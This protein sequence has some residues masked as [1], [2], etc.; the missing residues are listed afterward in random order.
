MNT[1][2]PGWLG[3]LESNQH[4][5]SQSLLK[6]GLSTR[7]VVQLRINYAPITHRLKENV[8]VRLFMRNGFTE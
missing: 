7:F 4:G 1:G 8:Y 3:W 5:Q 6:R 2:F